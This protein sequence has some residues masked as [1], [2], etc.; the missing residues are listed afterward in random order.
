MKQK[1]K[2]S[3]LTFFFPRRCAVCD[4]VVAENA[5]ICPDCA[6]KVHL[7]SGDICMICGKKVKDGSVYC[8]DCKHKKHEFV[9]NFAVF[10]YSDI[11]ESVYRFK[12][13]GRAEYA[14]YY[15]K[16]AYKLHGK[17]LD[18]LRADAIIPVPLHPSKQRKRGYNQAEEFA[19][20][21]SVIMGIPVRTDLIKRCKR[22]KPL[23]T[24]NISER[25]NNLKKAFLFTQND[26]K[27]ST[28]ILVDDIY[29]TGA[30]LD[31]VAKECHKAG[32]DRIYA[33]TVAVGTGL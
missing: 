17:Q 23:K 12:Y 14:G 4:C 3:L 1:L 31:A 18:A 22:T 33:I 13:S 20:E 16:E 25:Q 10:V 8:Y 29:T 7:L 24:L 30:T 26:V 6:K 2:E 21:L 32:I 5:Q 9:R 27:L 15:A 11:R 28:I 19:K